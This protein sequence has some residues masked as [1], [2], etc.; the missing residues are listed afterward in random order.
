[1]VSRVPTPGTRGTLLFVVELNYLRLGHPP[2]GDKRLPA[3]TTEG[4]E[5]EV[6][7]ALETLE[8][9]RHEDV[10]LTPAFVS[11]VC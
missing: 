6:S 1:M 8:A 10:I 9:A 5:V 11:C 2:L 3:V 4:D 7:G